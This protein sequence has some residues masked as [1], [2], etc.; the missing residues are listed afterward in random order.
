MFQPDQDGVY[1][2]V[3]VAPARRMLALAI[4]YGLGVFVLYLAF[5]S[6]AG[7]AG[8]VVMI[9]IGAGCLWAGERMRRA[10]DVSILLTENGVETS[11]GLMLATRDEIAIVNRGALAAKPSTGFTLVLHAPKT[12][13]WQPG[14]WWRIGR[15]VG[16]GGITSAGAAKF[17]AEQIA[18]RIATEKS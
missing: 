16:V 1:A 14:M 17:M 9:A 10:A 6:L 13:L 18:L 11:T 12:R 8:A 15:R 2:R 5:S 4:L 3:D 7:I